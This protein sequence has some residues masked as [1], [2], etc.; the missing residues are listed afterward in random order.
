[1]TSSAF[2][3]SG[4]PALHG[5]AQHVAGRDLRDAEAR[6]EPLRLRALARAGRPEEDQV[7]LATA[8]MRYA[9]CLTRAAADARTLAAR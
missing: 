9:R 1:M 5:G 3:P 7:A 4:V 2:L 8:S 6:R